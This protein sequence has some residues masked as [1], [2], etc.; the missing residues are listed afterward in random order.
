MRFNNSELRR[1]LKKHDTKAH[2]SPVPLSDKKNI[3]LSCFNNRATFWCGVRELTHDRA[4]L[5][6]TQHHN[7]A[8]LSAPRGAA[9]LPTSR[10]N[11]RRQ[12]APVRFV[13]PS[14]ASSSRVRVR[15]AAA[16]DSST[17]SAGVR[18]LGIGQALIDYAVCVDEPVLTSLCVVK[19]GRR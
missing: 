15:C 19:G 12:P 18:V 1:L 7:M 5:R 9:L 3:S 10:Q 11:L 8:A 16:P 13:A 6:H 14:R 17:P 4:W 2:T